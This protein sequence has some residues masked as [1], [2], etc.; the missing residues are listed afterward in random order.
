MK[1]L[2]LNLD[3]DKKGAFKTVA[4]SQRESMTTVLRKFID[5]Y[6][7]NPKKV[8]KFIEKLILYNDD[9]REIHS[10]SDG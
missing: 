10:P 2:P 1:I 9:A 7:K 8:M 3:D 4:A 5:A 6:I